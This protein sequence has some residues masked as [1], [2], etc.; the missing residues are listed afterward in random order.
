[1]PKRSNLFQ[2]LVQLL[3][4]HLAPTDATVTGSKLLK[5]LR[6]GE[7]REVDI[8]IEAS[9]GDHPVTIG[10]E[11]IDRKRKA[12]TPWVEG[13]AK[14][15]ED[16]PIHK[17]VLVSR[18]GYFRPA[19]A[20]ADAYKMEA[21]TIEQARSHDWTATIDAIPRIGVDMFVVPRLTGCQVHL[22]DAD[23]AG[24]MEGRQ[25]ELE[26]SMVVAPSG[27]DV[28][29]LQDLL[30]SLIENPAFV[31][32]AR[33]Q[34]FRNTGTAIRGEYPLPASSKLRLPTGEEHT[35]GRIVFSAHC[36]RHATD[37]TLIRGRYR[38]RAVLLSSA[39]FSGHHLQTVWT[40]LH[41]EQDRRLSLQF[42]KAPD[43]S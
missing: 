8:V 2:D 22:I 30:K 12:D 18:S 25:H 15:H 16:L 42:K 33:R 4:A 29:L 41:G 38:D 43:D 17:T 26:A 24:A 35:I 3:E 7:Q 10:V 40:E 11:V 20:K 14:K 13:I 6:T 31:A 1:M 23:A 39:E 34:A 36:E 32:E 27:E 9:A 37:S 5:D 28:G 21:L 19:K